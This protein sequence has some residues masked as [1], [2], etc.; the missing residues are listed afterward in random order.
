M[1]ASFGWLLS[2]AVAG[3]AGSQASSSGSASAQAGSGANTFGAKLDSG[4]EV[5]PPNV[6]SATPSGTAIFT[7]SGD[8]LQY[9]VSASGLTSPVTM[10]HIH[11]GGPGVAGPVIVPLGISPGSGE[12]TAQGEGTIDAAQINGKNP[13]GSAMTMDDLLKA[14]RSGATY[15]NVHTQNNKPGEVRGEIRP[16]G[17]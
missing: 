1:R 7:R 10:A 2:L 8:T 5:P 11:L 9:R 12:G 17:S 14:M 6:G 15:V 13:D 4:S 16:Q 3:C